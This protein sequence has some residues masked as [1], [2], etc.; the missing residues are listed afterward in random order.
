M[1]PPLSHPII[2][3]VV[4]VAGALASTMLER[5]LG[6]VTFIQKLVYMSWGGLIF[7]CA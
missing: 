1:F 7:L 3:V 2:L 4:M 6:K 5:F